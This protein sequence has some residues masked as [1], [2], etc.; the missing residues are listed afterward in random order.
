MHPPLPRR[1]SSNDAVQIWQFLGTAYFSVGIFG[2][3]LSEL[4]PPWL[5]VRDLT[6]YGRLLRAPASLH[7]PSSPSSPSTASSVI[8]VL[9]QRVQSATIPKSSA[10]TSFY[11]FAVCVSIA[12][13]AI[14]HEAGCA[15]G[16]LGV[17]ALFL[18]HVTRR[19]LECLLVVAPSSARV[20]VAL[21]AF[22]AMHYAFAA[23][24]L[25]PTGGCARGV[26]ALAADPAAAIA[27]LMLLVAASA[28]QARA[29]CAFGAIGRRRA[30]V[31]KLDAY[32][33]PSRADSR[34]FSLCIAPHYA[35]E[36][37]I[38]AAF[39]AL[40]A[41]IATP[42]AGIRGGRVFVGAVHAATP[43]LVVWVVANLGVT[44]HRL[45]D[46]YVKADPKADVPPALVPRCCS[47][48]A[49]THSR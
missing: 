28:A 6:L 17:Q 46:A 27:A 9:V 41:A 29:H 8:A 18:A 19:L 34:L 36:M 31:G 26:D 14:A 23:V 47:S 10:F 42:G 45:R 22:G 15:R 5:P 12:V 40:R 3:L 20:P 35:A 33:L 24:A 7:A 43:T 2:S 44:A 48:R 21:A 11:V 49:R 39:V 16:A 1:T 4:L 38:Y 13:I 37:L 25:L 30:R 32:P